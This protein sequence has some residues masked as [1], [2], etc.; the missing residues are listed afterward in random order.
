VDKFG[1]SIG[2]GLLVTGVVFLYQGAFE[3]NSVSQT[4]AMI[5]GAAFLSLGV[6][7]VSLIVKDWWRWKRSL[8]DDDKFV[9]K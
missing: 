9:R 4:M 6:V 3:R 8:K 7:T 2:V 5:S 1:F